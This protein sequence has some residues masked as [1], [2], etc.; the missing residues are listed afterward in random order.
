MLTV[1]DLMILDPYTVYEDASLR[2]ALMVL[3]TEGYRQVPVLSQE[4][5]L[6][7]I[8]TDR[9][10]RLVMN[11]PM[12]GERWLNDAVLDNLTVNSCMTSNP[13]TV[14]PNLPIHEAAEM[15]SAY[16]F[17]GLPVVDDGKL[18]GILTVTN[19]LDYFANFLK[20]E[21]GAP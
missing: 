20:K 17:G 21:R 15:M 11:S 10:I 4:G 13:I 18:V 14:A 3:R 7:G 6:V 16:K 19:I 8:I 5:L 1:N 9:D 12:V 2:E